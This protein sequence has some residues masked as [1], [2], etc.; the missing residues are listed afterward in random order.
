MM[1]V[2]LDKSWTI[3]QIKILYYKVWFFYMISYS[4]VVITL[5]FESSIRRSNRRKRTYDFFIFYF[6][7]CCDGIPVVVKPWTLIFELS[8]RFMIMNY[9]TIKVF[10]YERIVLF[11]YSDTYD[12]VWWLEMTKKR[13]INRFS[14]AIGIL[15]SRNLLL[16][17]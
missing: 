6:I 9:S 16:F 7:F 10:Y 11:R 4:E 5:D 14:F 13:R 2:N 17:S 15:L 3:F 1:H 12:D 8:S